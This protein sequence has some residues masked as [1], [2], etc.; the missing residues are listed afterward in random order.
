VQQW[1]QPANVSTF[2]IAIYATGNVEY[3]YLNCASTI[4]VLTGW[5]P[6][7]G[8]RDPGSTD[9]SA[10]VALVCATDLYPLTHA[11]STRPVCGA[12]VQLQTA[13]LPAG[14]LLGGTILGLT[15]FFPGIDLGL[16]GMPGCALYASL[17][18][19]DLTVPS[20]SS[21]GYALAIPSS[22]SLVGTTVLTQGIAHAPWGNPFG[23]TTS[24]G[25]RLVVGDY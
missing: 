15:Q 9:V 22:V 16:I 1:N 21:F 14:S 2:Q 18:V 10:L 4:T 23:M 24:N 13:D 3:R 19:L 7:G 20:A 12:T 6:G 25:L 8:A 5:S 17:D 11:T